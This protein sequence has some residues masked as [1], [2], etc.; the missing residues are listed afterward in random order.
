MFLP[1]FA[2]LLC[3]RVVCEIDI[4]TPGSSSRSRRANVVLPA[5]DG[6]DK[7]SINPLRAESISPSFDVLHL[8]AQLIDHGLELHAG[9]ADL[10][11]G[12][13][14]ADRVG[15]AVELLC[16]KIEL[17]PDRLIFRKQ[18]PRSRD[19]RA[20]AIELF[21]NVGLGGDQKCL[22]MQPLRI[23][24]SAV[25]DYPP[26][27]FRELRPHRLR[28]PRLRIGCSLGE[29]CD[30]IELACNDLAEPSALGTPRGHKLIECSLE[31]NQQSF[32]ESRLR[33]LIVLALDRLDHAAHAEQRIEPRMFQIGDFACAF[34][35]GHGL[36]QRRLVE[37]ELELPRLTLDGEIDGA[38][39]PV[40]L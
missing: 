15:F 36:A 30:L 24:A 17:P 19:M 29:F 2:P 8:L 33:F 14:G 38:I 7:T 34:G 39:A 16:E 22:L 13:L 26:E 37:L 3:S 9:A 28:L 20:Q 31:S 27:L 5:P 1:C 21:L 23:E 11:I 10:E 32:G 4:S 35:N 25:F 18:V 12:G 40:E 6:D